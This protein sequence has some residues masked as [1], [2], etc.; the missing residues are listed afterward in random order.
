[1]RN[2]ALIF[3]GESAEHEVSI[4]TAM[5]ILNGYTKEEFNLIPLFL[6]KNN[7]WFLG[8]R[9]LTPKDYINPENNKALKKVEFV[10]GCNAFKIV[11]SKKQP[12][13]F[14]CAILA[15]HGGA[16]ENGELISLLNFVKIKV[17]GDYLGQALGY[18]KIMA[19]MICQS[20]KINTLPFKW[21]YLSEWKLSP[22]NILKEIKKLGLPVIVKPDR[23]GSSIGVSVCKTMSEIVQ[24]VNLAFE[25]DSKVIVEPALTNFREFNCSCLGI[26]GEKILVSDVD[27]PAKIHDILT[28][29]D[30]Y[31]GSSKISGKQKISKP[32]SKAT[33]SL[34]K[35]PRSFLNDQKLVERIKTISQ[36]I[37]RLLNLNGVVRID[38]LYDCKKKKVYFNEVN[39]VPGSL[40][41]YFW[42]KVGININ[43][44]V[45]MLVKIADKQAEN[46][47]DINPDFITKI[48]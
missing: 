5:Q 41:F 14:D 40:A 36:R 17:A 25:F 44:L 8:E 48:I 43:E 19:K 31:V 3:G 33:G 42:Q 7:T 11:K 12:L 16:G 35:M 45:A 23:Q 32:V 30:K 46:S 39:T 27:E 9:G 22:I 10:F 29:E 21:F 13:H 37:T 2:V 20:Q 47:I 18:D 28:F 38:Y 4:I 15:T 6:S 24:A 26:A 1:M 34:D